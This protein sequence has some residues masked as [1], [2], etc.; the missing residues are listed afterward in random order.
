MRKLS[1]S[2]LILLALSFTS[3]LHAQCTAANTQIFNAS[4]LG[5]NAG[6]PNGFGNAMLTFNQNG[7]G[8]L[9]SSTLG[10]GNNINSISLFA[11]D[12]RANGQ[13]VETFTTTNDG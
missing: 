9:T 4:L 8:T 7:I 6:T 5:T 10:L 2:F 1:T 13:L 11:G 3:G 12:P